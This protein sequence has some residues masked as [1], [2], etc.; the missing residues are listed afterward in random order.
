MSGTWRLVL[1]YDGT[2]FAGWQRQPG[3]RTVQAELERALERLLGGERVT[4]VA[5][6]RTDAGVHALGQVVSFRCTTPRDPEAM[7]G[8]LSALLPPDISCL[9]A[10]RAAADF[11]ARYSALGKTYAYRIQDEGA[12]PALDRHRVWY[13]G[14]ALDLVAMQEAARA[15]VG[16][17]DFTSLRAAG[18][19]A[20]HP[21]CRLDEVEVGRVGREVHVVV[22]GDRFLRHM[23]RNLVGT[24]VE[25]GRGRR[26]PGEMAELLDARDRSRAGPTAPPQGLALVRVHYARP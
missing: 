6:G 19:V 17:H 2:D 15:F 9:E 25:V 23:V 8:G 4:T 10:G 14:R 11:H 20:R 7:L 1:E 16:L 24:L 13:V 22:R 5:A 12:R 26:Q 21:R 18:C 3:Q